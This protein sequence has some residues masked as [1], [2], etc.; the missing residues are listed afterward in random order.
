MANAE[1][2]LHEL[3]KKY[4]EQSQQTARCED[5]NLRTAQVLFH[6]KPGFHGTPLP[7]RL[8]VL[9]FGALVTVK[10]DRYSV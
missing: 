6:S 2:S 9:K 10:H 5:K 4:R 7:A 1:E 3:F 8:G